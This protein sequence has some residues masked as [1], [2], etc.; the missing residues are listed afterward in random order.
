M[1]RTEVRAKPSDLVV[2]TKVKAL[3]E[4][5]LTVT[6]KSP[7]QFRFTLVSRMQNLALDAVEHIYRANEE[8]LQASSGGVA[9]ARLAL[10]HQ[11]LCDLKLLCYIAEIAMRQG[12]VLMKQYEHMAKLAM[13]CCNLLGAWISSDKKRLTPQEAFV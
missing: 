13:D 8:L 6:Q 10:Q 9:S 2:V 12:C 5:V 7:K 4:Y 11:A 1:G 3:C